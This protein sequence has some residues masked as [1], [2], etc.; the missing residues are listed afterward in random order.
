MALRRTAQTGVTDTAGSASD[1]DATR[2][3]SGGLR[4]SLTLPILTLYGLGNI[5]GAGIYVLVGKVAGEAGANTALAFI[6]AMAIAGLTAF[7]YMELSSRFPQSASVSVYLHKAFGLRALSVGIG[8]VLVLGGIASAAALSQG[9]AGYLGSLLD[10]P[11]LVAAIGLL[12][13]MGLLAARGIGASA[14]FA[15]AITLIEVAG[16]LLII[17]FGLSLTTT[18]DVTG[19]FSVDPAVGLGGVLIGAFLAFYAFIGFEDMVNV[20]EE[21]KEPRRTMPRA[22]ILSLVLATVLYLLVVFVSL[23]V[24]PPSMLA[25]SDAPLNL[26]FDYIGRLNPAMGLNPAVI[27]LIGLA[28]TVNGVLVQIIMGS[29]ILYGL[30]RQG[31]LPQRFASVS[32]GSRTPLFAT[33]TVVAAMI[34]GTLL[35][36]LVSLARLTSFLVLSVFVLVNLSLIVIKLRDR[37]E[38]APVSVPIAV[39]ALALLTC[40]GLVVFQIAA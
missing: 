27:S 34:A 24:V 1:G 5:L 2:G 20:V 30:S 39:P 14:K 11:Q 31:W 22:I 4:R 25:A 13:V 12:L 35:L 40:L 3:A 16:L 32:A 23:A 37:G 33:A 36:S 17:G 26:V 21:V 7:S 38:R 29:R 10:V 15:A 19:I 8:L 18:A 9:F 28:A 6:V